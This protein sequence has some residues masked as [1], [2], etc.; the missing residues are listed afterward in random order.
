[1]VFENVSRTTT[2]TG[3]TFTGGYVS[4][5]SSDGRGGGV[6]CYASSP[7]F[8]NCKFERN[9]AREG[10]A[11]GCQYGSMPFLNDCVFS[12]NRAHEAAGL[13]CIGG[14]SPFLTN[15]IFTA[16]SSEGIGG[17]MVC[18]M[19]SIPHLT[20]CLFAGNSAGGDGGAIVY[21]GNGADRRFTL[22]NCTFVD[23]SCTGNGSLMAFALSNPALVNC[24]MAFNDV[25]E[26]IY[27]Y[28]PVTNPS[29]TCC[30]IYGN[31][32]GDWI[33]Y[34]Y[35]QFGINGNISLDPMF[36]DTANNDYRIDGLSPCLVYNND[37][38]A[39]IGALGAGCGIICGDASGDLLLNIGDA[40]YLIAY[41]FREGPAPPVPAAVDL[42]GNGETDVGDVTMIINYI[43]RN[44]L[45]LDCL[46]D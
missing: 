34:I 21:D 18:I 12:E 10:G 20:G 27:R 5:Y 15:C 28:D 26:T 17:G 23:N 16:N 30:D 36:C 2:I 42:N 19:N 41:L 39:T 45:P 44:G 6:Y 9:T 22:T 29:L 38:G 24:L 31:A 13:V 14:S 46:W 35:D 3:F 11:I 7:V 43:F 37:C 32:G 8:N 33:G 4:G 1:M 25:N 40:V